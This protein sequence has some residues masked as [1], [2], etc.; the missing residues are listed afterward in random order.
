MHTKIFPEIPH[1]Y[2][3]T[4]QTVL[5]NKHLEMG[6]IDVNVRH[7][8]S[9]GWKVPEETTASECFYGQLVMTVSIILLFTAGGL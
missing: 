6:N 5:N 4:A 2:L 3:K 1:E 8:I 7:D 9:S